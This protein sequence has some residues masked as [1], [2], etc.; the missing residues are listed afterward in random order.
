MSSAPKSTGTLKVTT[1]SDREVAFT[2]AFNAPRHLIY[3]AWTKPALLKR[4]LFGPD[5]WPLTVCQIDLRVGGALRFVWRHR[6]TG[7][8]M[9]MSGVYREIV[10]SERIVHTEVWDEDWTGGETLVTLIFAEHAGITTATQTVLYSSLAARDAAL[11]TGMA[12]GMG[13][14]YDRLANLLAHET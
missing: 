1:P 9:G 11:K 5:E 2:R 13:Q 14:S 10:P 12:E 4:W 8:D 3:E 6:D 7:K